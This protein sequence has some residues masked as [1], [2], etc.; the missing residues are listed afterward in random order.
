MNN[1][2]IPAFWW[3]GLNFS[4]LLDPDWSE[5]QSRGTEGKPCGASS[6]SA[7]E[8]MPLCKLTTKESK[9]NCFCWSDY[10]FATKSFFLL[11][12]PLTKIQQKHAWQKLG[13]FQSRAER[14]FHFGDRVR[15]G[16]EGRKEQEK[17]DRL[18]QNVRD[19][20]GRGEGGCM[21]LLSKHACFAIWSRCSRPREPASWTVANRWDLEGLQMTLGETSAGGRRSWGWWPPVLW[22]PRYP[23]GPSAFTWIHQLQ[24][25]SPRAP[26]Q[27][28]KEG[29]HQTQG[30]SAPFWCIVTDHAACGRLPLSCR[31][32]EESE[33]GLSVPSCHLMP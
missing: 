2:V 17:G 9:G 28:P 23:P 5:I 14:N 20:R 25:Q 21:D 11:A 31:N 30:S 16:G 26:D 3:T 13:V 19:R 24:W 10:A 8:W 27:V 22:R 6:H 29:W 15:V 33:P 4:K 7:R 12:E 1:H 18:G 32:C